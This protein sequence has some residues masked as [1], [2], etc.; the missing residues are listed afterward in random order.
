MPQADVGVHGSTVSSWS[1]IPSSRP[2]GLVTHASGI[3]E[4]DE[5]G[6]DRCRFLP[7]A[8]WGNFNVLWRRHKPVR[9]ISNGLWSVFNLQAST[10]VDMLEPGHA[11]SK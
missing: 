5:L 6:L 9:V 11:H 4:W 3:P 2:Q 7:L 8:A 10:R 1:E